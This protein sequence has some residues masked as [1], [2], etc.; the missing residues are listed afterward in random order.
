MDGRR[1]DLPAM[2]AAPL[3][4]PGHG[5]R[6][7]R[8]DCPGRNT[9]RRARSHVRRDRS[10]QAAVPGGAVTCR[11]FLSPYKRKSHRFTTGFFFF[12]PPARPAHR[13]TVTAAGHLNLVPESE[14]RQA[15]G[16][17]PTLNKS[18]PCSFLFDNTY[19][20]FKQGKHT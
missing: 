3:T 8:H 14:A 17:L 5:A 7:R 16:T 2:P 13:A 10:R 11:F 1:L 20:Y 9:R 4:I 18:L 19:L 12:E 6:R 15:R